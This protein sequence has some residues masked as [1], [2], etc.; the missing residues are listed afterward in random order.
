MFRADG[1]LIPHH[2]QY[3]P[4]VRNMF[5]QL[6]VLKCILFICLYS[7]SCRDEKSYVID[8]ITK[9]NI[10]AEFD[11]KSEIKVSEQWKNYKELVKV[12]S[13]TEIVKLCE[14]SNPI[15]RTYAFRHL[16]D[17]KYYDI[18]NILLSH[19]RDT[20]SFISVDGCVSSIQSVS[21]ICLTKVKYNYCNRGVNRGVV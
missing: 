3:L 14:H 2:R 18:Y 6:L 21:D 12:F 4:V 7:T 5:K 15:V 1:I 9:T 8:S 19:L 20:S 10:Y 11:S 16:S 13:V 17:I